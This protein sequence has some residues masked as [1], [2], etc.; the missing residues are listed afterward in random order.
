MGQTIQ[1]KFRITANRPPELV[2]EVRGNPFLY[3][4]VL[5]IDGAGV[6]L[7]L[8]VLEHGSDILHFI[9]W[10]SI[11]TSLFQ[12]LIPNALYS[13][14]LANVRNSLCMSGNNQLRKIILVIVRILKIEVLQ[15]TIQ[16]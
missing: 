13:V 14:R 7:V 10:N 8:K 12:L 2:L 16:Q 15:F 6:T 1:G 3:L 11:C 5:V 4:F 9:R